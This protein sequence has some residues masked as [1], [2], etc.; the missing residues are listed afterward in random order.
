MAEFTQTRI[1]KASEIDN[2]NHVNNVIY[3]QW[4]QEIAELHW[5]ELT[6]NG[7]HSD[8]FWVVLRHEI[9]Y[10]GQA[11]L[12]DE[13]TLKT[14]VGET[15]GVKSVRHVSISKNNKIIAKAATTWCLI[16]AATNKPNRV[17]ESILKTLYPNK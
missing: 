11:L 1:V 12:N 16:N 15:S 9:D 7:T 10:K 8:Y 14:W 17:T 6:K 13:I 2:L 5:E 4:V 3:L